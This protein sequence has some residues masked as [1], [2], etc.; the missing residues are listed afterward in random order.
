MTPAVLEDSET[1][2]EAR[3]QMAICNACRYCES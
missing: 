1:V 3:R 2:A